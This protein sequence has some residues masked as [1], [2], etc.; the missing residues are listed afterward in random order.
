MNAL[1]A[2]DERIFRYLNQFHFP[3]LD[4]VMEV[5]TY[6]LTWIPLY[7]YVLYFLYKKARFGKNLAFLVLSVAFADRFTSG[8]MKPYFARLRPC[9]RADWTDWLH[10]VG[11][12]GG[13][14]GFASSHAANVFALTVGFSLLFPTEKRHRF[15]LFFWA[16][17]VSYSRV[18]VGVHFPLDIVVGGGVGALG[19]YV[20]F[21]M[22]TKPIRFS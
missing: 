10:L 12:C 16:A 19:A 5:V 17:L 8:W 20:L 4:G 6:K 14:F 21:R 22:Y 7:V 18:Y 13:Q 15:F 9:H 2:W 3:F 11:N 1:I